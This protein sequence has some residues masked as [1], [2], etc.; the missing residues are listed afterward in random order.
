MRSIASVSALV[1]ALAT[2]AAPARAELKTKDIEYKHGDVVLAG[3]L[4]WDD[5]VATT[6]KP[7]PGIVVCPE[8]WGNNGYPHERAKNLAQLGY[9]AFAIDLYG[10]G[11]LTDDPKEAAAWA[12][13]LYKDVPKMRARAKAGLDELMKQPQ[14][15]KSRLAVIGYCFGGTVALELA[16]TGAPLKAI[17]AFHPGKIAADGDDKKA[18]EDNSKIAGTVTICRGEADGFLTADEIKKFHEQMKAAKIDYQILSYAYA[19]HAFTNPDADKYKIPGIAYNA[20]ADHRS[21]E[22][23]KSAFAEAFVKR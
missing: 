22:H 2:L 14:V 10:K 3:F 11:K 9:V 15:D 6:E 21:W 4:A 18:L 20:K 19:V 12:G 7:Q 16:R 5:A 8:W 23:M 13:E 1:L 17:V